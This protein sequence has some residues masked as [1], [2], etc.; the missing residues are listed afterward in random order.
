MTSRVTTITEAWGFNRPTI[1]PLAVS[2]YHRLGGGDIDAAIVHEI[3]VRQVIEQNGITEFDLSFDDKKNFV[4]PA[5]LSVAE[6][7]KVGLCSE[8]RRLESFGKYA[9]A[10]KASIVKVQPGLHQ[11]RT[12]ARELT[13]QSP[14]LTAAEFE[15]VLAPFIDTDLLY[16]VEGEY[17]VR[18]Q[19]LRPSRTRLSGQP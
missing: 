12:S 16:A 14:R 8:I 9:Q 1:S 3:L 13:L 19:S 18:A 7:L 11:F 15:K 6:A 4:E 5:L 17:R 2:R 10:D